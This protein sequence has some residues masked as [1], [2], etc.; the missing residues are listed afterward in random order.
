MAQVFKNKMFETQNV[1]LKQFPH[2]NNIKQIQLL[3]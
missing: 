1:I 3:L 2:N